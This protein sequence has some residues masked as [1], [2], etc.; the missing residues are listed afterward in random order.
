MLRPRLGSLPGGR[1]PH[2]LDFP[3]LPREALGQPPFPP[4]ACLPASWTNNAWLGTLIFYHTMGPAR[5]VRFPSFTTPWECTGGVPTATSSARGQAA[6]VR[7]PPVRLLTMGVGDPRTAAASPCRCI[8]TS[9]PSKTSYTSRFYV[10]DTSFLFF[11]DSFFTIWYNVP[12]QVNAVSSFSRSTPGKKPGKRR[13]W[14][15]ER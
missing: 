3:R 8:I 2:R 10:C 15:Q 4:P 5:P 11:S 6:S 1:G 13:L 12:P 14:I 9:P 7:P